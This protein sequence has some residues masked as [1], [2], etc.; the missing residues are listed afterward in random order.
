VPDRR[1]GRGGL[2]QFNTTFPGI[3]ERH[4][5]QADYTDRRGHPLNNFLSVLFG[6]ESEPSQ[7][8]GGK[9]MTTAIAPRL[10]A[11]KPRSKKI[12]LSGLSD[13]QLNDL[14]EDVFAASLSAW[15]QR[16][17]KAAEPFKGKLKEVK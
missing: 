9:K 6:V 3:A 13:K 8:R 1:G 12:D 11:R 2:S 7:R 5:T 4:Y 17:L 16:F 10:S 14:P 15:G